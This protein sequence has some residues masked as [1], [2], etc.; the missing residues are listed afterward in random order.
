MWVVAI[1]T[2]LNLICMIDFNQNV[3]VMKHAHNYYPLQ[4]LNYIVKDILMYAQ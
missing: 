4:N 1:K 2:L 3:Q